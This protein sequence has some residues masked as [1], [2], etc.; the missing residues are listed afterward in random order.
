MKVLMVCLGN[1]CRSPM[2]EGILRSKAA[3]R[4]IY[5]EVD[6]AGTGNYHS[7]EHP[8]P[9]AIATAKKFN[10][11]ISKQIA[12]QFAQADFDFYDFIFVMDHSNYS[13]VI[14]L[15]AS[16]E[17]RKKVSLM[18]SNWPESPLEEV[19]DPWFGGPEGFID[20]FKMLDK[21]CDCFLNEHFSN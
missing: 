21:A 18:L 12:R 6:S 4:K 17:H 20:V 3:Q 7:G 15:A 16:E 14:R 5:L 10:V 2:A 19:P 1:I 9:R 8:D 11:D 13:N